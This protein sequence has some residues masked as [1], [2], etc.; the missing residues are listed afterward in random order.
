MKVFITNKAYLVLR[1]LLEITNFSK[2]CFDQLHTI[3]YVYD[4]NFIINFMGLKSKSNYHFYQE[5]F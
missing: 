1:N 2:A 4:L 5:Y 3:S